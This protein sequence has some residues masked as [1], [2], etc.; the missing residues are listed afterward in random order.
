M[1]TVLSKNR[2]SIHL[3]TKDRMTELSQLLVSLCFQTYKEFDIVI[4]DSSQ[5]V[6]IWSYKPIAETIFRLLMLG[7]G[8]QTI[9]TIPDGVCNA[10]NKA[11]DE[12]IWKDKNKYVCRIDDDSVVEMDYLERLIN[13]IEGCVY[14]DK[15]CEGDMCKCEKRY[16]DVKDIIKKNN[17]GAVGCIVP[18]WSQP[19]IIR[20]V[21]FFNKIASEIKCDEEGNL[22]Y[23][24]IIKKNNIGAVGCI[25]PLWSQPAIIRDVKFFN[26]IASEIKCDEEGNLLY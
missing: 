12:D 24:D 17:I 19:A 25:V 18:L 26:K 4:V 16:E 6:P 3:I 5:P 21:K 10:R 22:L 8:V 7:H 15:D 9:H 2:I 23:I 11:I 14:H 1:E 13:L 20:D